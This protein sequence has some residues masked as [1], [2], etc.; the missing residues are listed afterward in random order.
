[1]LP[2][3]KSDNLKEIIKEVKLSPEEA[4]FLSKLYLTEDQAIAISLQN[5]K[6][7]HCEQE[8]R[9]NYPRLTNEQ[10]LKL[11]NSGLNA[12]GL[13]SPESKQN[14]AR[15]RQQILTEQQNF[16]L[17][18]EE[19]EDTLRFFINQLALT[20]EQQNK[21][22]DMGI[23]LFNAS[24][25][26]TTPEH[27]E[28]LLKIGL[29]KIKLSEAE[30]SKLAQNN[31]QLSRQN[32][33]ILKTLSPLRKEYKYSSELLSAIQKLRLK[34]ESLSFLTQHQIF[35]DQHTAFGEPKDPYK[36]LKQQILEKEQKKLF[37]AQQE[38]EKEASRQRMQEIRNSLLPSLLDFGQTN[39][40]EIIQL[41]LPIYR[42]KIIY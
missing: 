18:F 26:K 42:E 31:P 22:E 4:K 38:A 20:N 15:I 1:V 29:E 30:K 23:S 11:L 16:D 41:E 17:T 5:K 36:S 12:L 2:A 21:L 32:E 7:K 34:Y 13:K 25:W 6:A 10:K 14:L 3:K 19:K 28:A 8:L 40:D 33:T 27:R 35:P 24:N 37:K 39:P 9:T